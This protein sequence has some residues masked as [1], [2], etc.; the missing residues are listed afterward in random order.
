MIEIKNLYKTF[1]SELGTEKQVFN[2]LNLKI[3]D[4]DFLRNVMESLSEVE[5]KIIMDRYFDNKTQMTVA[6]ELD[7]SQM[8]VSR[9]EKKIL[10][11]LK[12]E[13]EKQF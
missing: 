1:F 9:M 3:E 6:K 13:Y 7:I 5:K 12:K 8:T 4:G 11:K 2:N 10:T